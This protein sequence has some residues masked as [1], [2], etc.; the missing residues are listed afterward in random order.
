MRVVSTKP[1]GSCTRDDA[2]VVARMT[3]IASLGAG[4]VHVAAAADHSERAILMVGFEVVAVL[5]VALGCLLLWRRPSANVLAA[6]LALMIVSIGLWAVSRT[7]GLG[8]IAGEHVEPVGFRDSVTVLFQLV[9]CVGLWELLQGSKR[10]AAPAGF[11]GSP[12]TVLGALAIALGVP[13]MIT[14]GHTHG[15]HASL[16]HAGGPGGHAGAAAEHEAGGAH[17]TGAGRHGGGSHGS[18]AHGSRHLAAGSGSSVHS[19]HTQLASAGHSG[20]TTGVTGLPV[21]HAHGTVP[22]SGHTAHTVGAAPGTTH[23]EAGHDTAT[24]GSHDGSTG[25]GHTPSPGGTA[26]PPSHGD[27]PAAPPPAEPDP[28]PTLTETVSDQLDAL[29][30]GRG[31]GR[32]R[33]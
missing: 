2:R 20:H 22:T 23:T 7:V 18:S 27:D 31:H 28:P 26:H 1:Y 24:G 15:P 32:G 30:P 21:T 17:A 13:A 12:V 29:V 11:P 4:M 3:A 19:G 25:A 5:Q 16:V 10:P 6:G 33:R 14:G 9:A 8:F